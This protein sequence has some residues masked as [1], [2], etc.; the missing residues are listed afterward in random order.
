MNPEMMKNASNMIAGMSVSQIQMYL[1]QMGMSGIDHSMFRSM[2]QNM[3]NLSDS[4]INSM[5]TMA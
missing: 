5:K 4:Q 1:S 3:P 2:C